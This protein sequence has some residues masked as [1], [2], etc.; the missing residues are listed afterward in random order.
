MSL[1]NNIP[2]RRIKIRI[3]VCFELMRAEFQTIL[4]GVYKH[5]LLNAYLSN[6][7][8]REREIEREGERENENESKDRNI[9]LM[10]WG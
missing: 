3:E 10:M 7:L 4:M 9:L 2:I 1:W 5:H 8:C 6:L